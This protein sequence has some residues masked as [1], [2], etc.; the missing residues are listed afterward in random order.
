M[1]A[2]LKVI[3]SSGPTLR[4][5]FDTFHPFFIFQ[6]KRACV[7]L[8]SYSVYRPISMPFAYMI[9]R[10]TSA[11]PMFQ[12]FTRH[13]GKVTIFI[14]K[15]MFKRIHHLQRV[16]HHLSR[17]PRTITKNNQ[18]TRGSN[19]RTSN[20]QALMEK[21]DMFHFIRF[22]SSCTLRP[23]K[24]STTWPLHPCFH[25]TI[26]LNF[27][28]NNNSNLHHNLLFHLPRR[29]DRLR[30]IRRLKI[31]IIM[32]PT[33][34]RYLQRKSLGI[35]L[36][37][38]LYFNVSRIM[39]MTANNIFRVMGS[40]ALSTHAHASASSCLIFLSCLRLHIHNDHSRW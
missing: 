37:S 33:S 34:A 7:L 3:R 15:I 6:L 20:N 23:F 2:L 12:A 17:L 1:S 10:F 39:R 13:R 11:P 31:R 8:I 25:C 4:T 26:V 18:G 24:R 9:N 27:L 28:F 29:R 21:I 38:F 5:H 35:H 36:T 14:L 19:A 16:N 32:M 30:D 40:M 22:N